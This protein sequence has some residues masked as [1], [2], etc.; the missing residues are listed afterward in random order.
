MKVLQEGWDDIS[1]KEYSEIQDIIREN[2]TTFKRSLELLCYLTD[3]DEWEDM[4]TT[5]IIKAY[6]DCK[7]LSQ[8]PIINSIP[9]KIGDYEL[10][11]L[12]K[13]TLAEW[14][15]LDSSIIAMD[16]AKIASLLYRKT[17]L[18]EWGNIV[19]EPYEYSLASRLELYEDLPITSLGGLFSSVNEY[20]TK[21]LTTYAELFDS[22]DDGALTEEEKDLLSEA[23]IK[24]I[25]ASMKNDNRKKDFAWQKLLDDIS[26]GNWSTIPKVLELPHSFVFNMRLAKKVYGD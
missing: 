9:Q 2:N 20:R 22:Y 1:V 3:S 8:P 23:E 15:D 5:A 12:S 21:L 6:L 16:N 25:E 17:K 26:A 24:D 13:L 14:I 19:Y 18:D 4:S 11:P 10:K 7:W